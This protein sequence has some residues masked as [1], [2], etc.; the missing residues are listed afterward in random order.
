MPGASPVLALATNASKH[1]VSQPEERP[2]INPTKETA[3]SCLLRVGFFLT[4]VA[5]CCVQTPLMAPLWFYFP[6]DAELAHRE[7]NDAFMFGPKYLAAPVLEQGAT[8]RSL[9]LPANEGG[10]KHYYTGKSYPGAANVTVPAPYDELPL[11]VRE[12]Q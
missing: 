6:H 11:F 1:G 10:W 4:S 12:S 5:G 7:I 2:P 3:P 9:Y 8:T